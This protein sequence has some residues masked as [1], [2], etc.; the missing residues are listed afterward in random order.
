MHNN[1]DSKDNHQASSDSGTSGWCVGAVIA[2]ALMSA[3]AIVSCKSDE[4]SSTADQIEA[5]KK[6]IPHT[7]L[8]PQMNAK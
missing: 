5:I 7:H 4:P 8:Q 2:V 1:A 6:I 3:F